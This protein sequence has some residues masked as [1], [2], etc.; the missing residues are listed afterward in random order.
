MHLNMYACNETNLMQYVSSVYSVTVPL[1]V[2]GLLVVCHQE[3]TM[4][5]CK[6]W[7]VLY[8][9]VAQKTKSLKNVSPQGCLCYML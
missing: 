9:R 5:I 7:Y 8:I 3:V 4:Y 1:R 2:L 6:K